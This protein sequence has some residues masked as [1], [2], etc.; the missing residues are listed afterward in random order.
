[1]AGGGRW[2]NVHVDSCPTSSR[3]PNRPS[4]PE[5]LSIRGNAPRPAYEGES[6][7]LPHR[8]S[9]GTE[10]SARPFNQSAVRAYPYTLEMC[11]SS[12]IS[13]FPS[14]VLSFSSE[15]GRLTGRCR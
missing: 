4:A 8:N 3:P 7:S 13:I 2:T 5:S 15:E 12:T 10:A 14:T 1:M 6:F 9:G 11:L